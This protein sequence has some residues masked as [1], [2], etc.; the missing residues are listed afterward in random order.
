MTDIENPKPKDD[1]IN[2]YLKTL[3]KIYLINKNLK[4]IFNKCRICIP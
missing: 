3:I 1:F 2:N 4:M